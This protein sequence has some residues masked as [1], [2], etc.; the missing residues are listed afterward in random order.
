MTPRTLRTELDA[1][2]RRELKAMGFVREVSLS[3]LRR[4]RDVTD[5]L[6]FHCRRTPDGGY[7]IAGVAGIAI[8]AIAD[9]LESGSTNE[10][11]V[12]PTVLTPFH[13]LHENRDYFEWPLDESH[14]VDQTVQSIVTELEALVLPYFTAY[15]SVEA[16]RNAL[17]AP[18]PPE[19]FVLSPQQQ[20]IALAALEHTFGSSEA[21]MRLLDEALAEL[22]DAPSKDRRAIESLRHRLGELGRAGVT[23]ES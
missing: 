15:G 4:R 16:M 19:C 2:L 13:F 12:T 7:R 23:A 8:D 21:A 6:R 9:L 10:G 22:R 5:V 17:A 3:Y 11:T 18:R 14:P 1:E 20:I